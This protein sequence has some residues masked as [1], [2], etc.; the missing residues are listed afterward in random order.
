MTRQNYLWQVRIKFTQKKAK[1]S[2]PVSS[3]LIKLEYPDIYIFPEQFYTFH[4]VFFSVLLSSFQVK[5]LYQYKN[6]I[7]CLL[8]MCHL[9]SYGL[10]RTIFRIGNCEERKRASTL[11]WARK[12]LD[13]KRTSCLLSYKSSNYN[14]QRR[15]KMHL[16]WDLGHVPHHRKWIYHVSTWHVAA[17]PLLVQWP[18]SRSEGR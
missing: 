14:K 3:R 11:Y 7:C 4:R 8:A 12:Q 5:T 9:Q 18:V 16:D 10:A 6:A 1:V 13:D 15:Y 2:W 17:T